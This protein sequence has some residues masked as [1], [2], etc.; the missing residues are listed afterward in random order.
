MFLTSTHEPRSQ[1]SPGPGGAPR[2]TP[3]RGASDPWT[4]QTVA[5]LKECG[6]P[7]S[8][9]RNPADGV[10]IERSLGSL[11]LEKHSRPQ[12]P[13]SPTFPGRQRFRVLS[14]AP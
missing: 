9:C 8:V 14:S 12:G 5:R 3:R 7:A 1:A 6:V 4:S 2:D 10:S 13:L 11:A